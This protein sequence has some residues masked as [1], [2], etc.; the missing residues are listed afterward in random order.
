[1]FYIGFFELVSDKGDCLIEEIVDLASLVIIKRN[2]FGV[3]DDVF[4]VFEA[5]AFCC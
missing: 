1:M 3:F 5:V 4:A 2:I